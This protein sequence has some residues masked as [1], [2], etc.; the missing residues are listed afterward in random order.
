ML[1]D[2]AIK[3]RFDDMTAEAI[4]M[5]TAKFRQILATEEKMMTSLIRDRNI[6]I[7]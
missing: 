7:E 4:H 6:K 1:A 3:K 5:D 2:T